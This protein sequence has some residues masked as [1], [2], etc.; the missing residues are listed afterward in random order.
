MRSIGNLQLPG[1]STQCMANAACCLTTI[2]LSK[3]MHTQYYAA[4]QE[5]AALVS[6]TECG[7]MYSYS[8]Q[9]ARSAARR[10]TP[11]RTFLG[12]QV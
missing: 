7:C 9:S 1:G 5:Q 11:P 4:E 2:L 8:L 10:R 3:D 12:S 6:C